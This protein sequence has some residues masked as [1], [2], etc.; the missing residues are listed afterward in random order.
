M[1]ESLKAKRLL[2]K[3]RKA[4]ALHCATDCGWQSR[5][6]SLRVVD[7]MNEIPLMLT[8]RAFNTDGSIHFTQVGDNPG[9]HPYWDPEYFGDTIMVH[10]KVWP[11]LKVASPK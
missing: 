9:I 3:L 7:E 4:T 11:N 5:A 8:D 10:G 6:R 2:F 1:G